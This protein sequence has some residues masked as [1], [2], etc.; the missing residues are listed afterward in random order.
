MDPYEITQ[1]SDALNTANFKAGETVITEGEMG[2]VFYIIEEGEA[3]AT[4]TFEPGKP[5]CLVKF[6][7]PGDY[8]GELALINNVK[9]TLSVIVKS[10]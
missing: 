5:A 8:F 6:Y 7:R 1:I 3:E 10:D 9:R 2:D 4:K